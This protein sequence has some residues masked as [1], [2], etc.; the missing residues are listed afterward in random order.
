VPSITLDADAKNTVVARRFVDDALA[1]VAT[2]GHVAALLVSEL[3]SNVI[4]HAAT[5]FELVITVGD[6]VR[7][8]VR[9]GAAVTEAF[10]DLIA[11]PPRRVNPGAASGRGLMLISTL[12]SRFGLEDLGAHGKSVWFEL[13]INPEPRPGL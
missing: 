5:T 7:V 11:N 6:S 13:P 9:D 10:R 12:A 3:V 1:G 4:R 2:D 8:E